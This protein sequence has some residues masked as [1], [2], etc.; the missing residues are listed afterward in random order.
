MIT[1]PVTLQTIPTT[2]FVNT[3]ARGG[4]GARALAQVQNRF[5]DAGFAP[6]FVYPKSSLELEQAAGAA[7]ESG[8]KLLVAMG[9]DGTVQALAN[10]VHGT[11]VSIGILPAGGGNDFAASLG[12][13][14]DPVQS[15]GVLLEGSWRNVDLARARTADGRQRLYCGGGGLG[16]DAETAVHAAGLARRFSGRF[17]Y[18]A[19]AAR[20][21]LTY[22]PVTVQIEFLDESRETVGKTVLVAAALNTPGYGAGLELAPEARIDDGQLNLVLVEPLNARE[23][24]GAFLSWI[25]EKKL[26][27]PKLTQR[28][29]TSVR[30]SSDRPCLFH[31]DGEILGPAPVIIEVV[32]K[33]V[34]LLAPPPG[35]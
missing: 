35:D 16:L 13:P 33:A 22:S 23:L 31:G 2:V 10:A 27:S 24:A 19:A 28:L 8:A 9:G 26:K 15:A 21:L 17:R 29:F 7:V 4:R 20:A 12:L 32:P 11:E 14:L 6:R 25:K 18:I 34:R 5:A 3:R 30:L 1:G